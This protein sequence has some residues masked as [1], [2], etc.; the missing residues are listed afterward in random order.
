MGKKRAPSVKIDS[1]GGACPRQ[2]Y[3]RIGEL[4]FY[5]RERHGETTV[6]LG[7]PD[8]ANPI[9]VKGDWYTYVNDLD[10][11]RVRQMVRRAYTQYP[12]ARRG[13]RR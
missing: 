8:P 13:K 12:V 2:A 3:G 4:A 7:P 5:V 10:E 11:A 9:G 6:R 1:L